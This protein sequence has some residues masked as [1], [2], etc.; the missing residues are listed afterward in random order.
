MNM[1]QT[2]YFSET[3]YKEYTKNLSLFHPDKSAVLEH[4]TE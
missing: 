1:G 2:G 4:I 3:R